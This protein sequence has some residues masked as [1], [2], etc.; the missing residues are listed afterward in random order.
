MKH[1]FEI[2]DMIEVKNNFEAHN[3]VMSGM[4]DIK[5]DI[6]AKAHD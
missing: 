5:D 3:L 1:L 4:Y 2:K 6:K